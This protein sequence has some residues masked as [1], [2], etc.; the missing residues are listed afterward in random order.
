MKYWPDRSSSATQFAFWRD[1]EP[2]AVAKSGNKVAT[3][4][5]TLREASTLSRLCE[6]KAVFY[7]YS[8]RKHRSLA[9]TPVQNERRQ[10]L[11]CLS[12]EHA[13]DNLARGVRAAS[14]YNRNRERFRGGPTQF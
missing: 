7:A 13:K 10:G 11:G 1:P 2:G 3:A 12:K 8:K 4:K 6:T 5:R 9:P 14:G